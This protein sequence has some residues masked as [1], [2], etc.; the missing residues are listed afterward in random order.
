MK[1]IENLETGECLL[2][3]A[4]KVK[5]GKVQLA[6]AEKIENPNVRPQS[7]VSI[8]NASDD[9]FTQTGKPRRAWMSAEPTDAGAYLDVDFSGLQNEGDEMEINKLC[10]NLHIQITEST[11][12]SE[13]DVQNYQTAAK[14]AG[15]GGEFILS[16]DGKYIYT[17]ST[18]VAG[19]AKHVFLADTVRQSAYAG[20]A[21]EVDADIEE[22]LKF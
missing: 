10:D 13:Y 7:I 12:G 15:N 1:T 5:G 6:F 3:S 19:S 18:I 16:S 11:Q 21:S 2:I 17:N 9:R 22:S 20:A 14:R 4:K 8:L